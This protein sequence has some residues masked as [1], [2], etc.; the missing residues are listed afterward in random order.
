[1]IP[2]LDSQLMSDIQLFISRNPG[3]RLSDWS[4]RSLSRRGTQGMECE[5]ITLS[6]LGSKERNDLLLDVS[7]W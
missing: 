7:R 1:M 2:P 3:L 5:M 4:R 6:K